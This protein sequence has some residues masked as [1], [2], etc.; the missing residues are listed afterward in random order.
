MIFIKMDDTKLPATVQRALSELEINDDSLLDY[1]M[2]HVATSLTPNTYKTYTNHLAKFAAHYPFPAK[3]EDVLQFIKIQNEARLASEGKP[4]ANATIQAWVNAISLAHRSAG[5]PDPTQNVIVEKV[6]EGVRRKNFKP[7]KQAKALSQQ[8]II[9]MSQ[10]TTESAVCDLRNKV[11]VLLGYAGG[12]R[13]EHLVGM[14]VE[15]IIPIVQ[16]GVNG[17]TIDFSKEKQRQ[18]R[19]RKIYIPRNGK[20]LSI[21]E[22]LE[23]W[24]AIT[25]SGF[26]FKE[27]QKD[28]GLVVSGKPMATRSIRKIIKNLAYAAQIKEWQQVSPHSLRVSFVTNSI[29]LGFTPQQ[30]AKQ[31]GQSLQMVMRYIQSEGLFV[32]NPVTKLL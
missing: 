12:L 1:V 5:H 15:N 24:L 25:G 17:Y 23:Q 8:Q 26:V 2:S 7:Q 29:H 6:L 22:P 27:V 20:L 31:T 32:N 14:R 19:S 30:I 9:A 10:V 21:G 4:Y 18:N 11:I 28:G 3:P 16:E 13:S